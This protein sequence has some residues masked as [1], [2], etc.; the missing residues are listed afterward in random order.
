MDFNEIKNYLES[1]GLF[2][3]QHRAFYRILC[4][5]FKV[6]KQP[7]SPPNLK[8]TL[9]TNQSRC[10]H[11]DLRNKHKIIEEGARTLQGKNVFNYVFPKL[12]N[13][14]VLDRLSLSESHFKQSIFNNINVIF[15]KSIILFDKLNLYL[16]HIVFL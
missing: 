16:K 12:I 2:C 10:N 1:I 9:I 15:S 6:L 14:F 5:S 7:N 11:Y 8:N 3:F 13:N 4:F